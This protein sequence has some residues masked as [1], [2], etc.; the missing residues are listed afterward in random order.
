MSQKSLTL[1]DL[2]P[3][4][5]LLER[6]R[7]K[8]A[9]RHGGI[10]TTFEVEDTFE[11]DAK[12]ELQIFPGAIFDRPEQGAEFAVA[13]GEWRQV[14]SE[15]VL[16]VLDVVA[17]EDGTVLLV[18][19]FPPGHS[20]RDWIQEHG[21]MPWKRVVRIGLQ[22]LG[23]LEQ[24]HDVDLVHGDVKPSTI[25]IT[26]D[27]DATL[28]DGGITPALWDIKHLGD[29]TQ[30]VGT[31]VYAPVEQFGGDAPDVQSDVYAT[32]TVLF[33]LLS[34][35]VP[36]KGKS[37]LEVF[38]AKLDRKPPS[39]SRAAPE[40]ELPDGLEEILAEGMMAD[41]NERFGSAGE[42]RERLETLEG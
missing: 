35:S 1:F 39:L 29:R 12:R 10:A 38:Q 41:S 28:V 9:C 18:T 11:N 31:P 25:Q 32:A 27:H 14:Q 37:F 3:G 42:F 17:L 8:K 2:V 21:K 23:G 22:L 33:E 26:K 30:L 4:K 24:V 5:T 36:W 13:M 40:V 15:S 20:L 16:S 7:V 19:D 6:F 34:G